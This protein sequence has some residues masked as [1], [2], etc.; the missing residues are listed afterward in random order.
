MKIAINCRSCL[1]PSYTGIGRYTYHLIKA[2]GE[3]DRENTYVLYARKGPF[4]FRKKVP[5]FAA[6]NVSVRADHFKAGPR[7]LLK[8]CAL[9]HAPGPEVIGFDSPPSVVTLHD[10]IF[11]TYPKGHT[12]STI[13]ATEQQLASIL[14]HSAKIICAS[15]STFN[16]LKTYFPEAGEKAAV[17][18]EAVDGDIFYPLGD[19]EKKEAAA[20][21]KDRGVTGPYILFV[22]TIEPRKNLANLLRAFMFLKEQKKFNGKLVVVGMKGWMSGWLEMLLDQLKV[23][24]EVI[25][26]GYLS[27]RELRYFYA[28]A[29]VYVFS[30]F[31]EGF[32]L[33]ILEAMACGAPV[34][35][36]N[37][38][39]CPEVAGGAALTVDPH[40]LKALTEAMA[41][42]INDKALKED[43]RQKGF[44][45]VKDFSFR[46]M[47]EET[48]E[49]YKEVAKR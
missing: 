44:R 41:A 10:L 3:I 15:Q 35:T 28:Q 12:A 32:G 19:G 23:R 9:Y 34:I 49:V 36:S 17:I 16:D 40:D 5:F 30:S 42:V 24:G 46:K 29:E 38:S 33:P 43:L 48:L 21:L 37:V 45:R 31:Y 8:D 6:K 25:F 20:V 2:L 7:K 22:G 47:A 18:Y 4:D 14:R 13:Q 27:N 11:K 39:S 26:P 1:N